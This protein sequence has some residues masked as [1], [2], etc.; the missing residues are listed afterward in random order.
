MLCCCRQVW[1]ESQAP[2][3]FRGLSR[4][5]GVVWYLTRT[6]W[7][8]VSYRFLAVWDLKYHQRTF[9]SLPCEHLWL[10][11]AFWIYLLLMHGFVTSYVGH[12]A[13][14]WVSFAALLML[15]CL[16][17]QRKVWFTLKFNWSLNLFSWTQQI[18]FLKTNLWKDQACRCS[19]IFKFALTA[20]WHS[21]F[22]WK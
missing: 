1:G 11:L 12:W 4:N 17:I 5:V 3:H 6:W 8:V 15:I 19:L 20:E 18:V 16:I 14:Y 7:V 22:L 9:W 10:S 21:I 13:K 2:R